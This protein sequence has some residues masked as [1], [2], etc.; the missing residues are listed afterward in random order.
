VNFVEYGG[1]RRSHPIA[2]GA[3]K[4]FGEMKA[5]ARR[6]GFPLASGGK[7]G[8]RVEIDAVSSLHLN[9][10]GRGV[11]WLLGSFADALY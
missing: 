8:A 2:A 7:L 1:I 6:D 10:S 9:G 5:S 11:G 4:A 3:A